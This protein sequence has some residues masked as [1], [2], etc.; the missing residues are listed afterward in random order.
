VDVEN[1]DLNVS[2]S[3]LH[4]G[5]E[6]LEA[7]IEGAL[8]PA[9]QAVVESHVRTCHRC[10]TEVE[11]W[12]ALFAAFSALPLVEPRAGFADRVMAGVRIHVPWHVRAAAWLG[13]LLPQTTKG[14]ALVAAF[15]ALPVLATGGAAAW[16]IR[17]PWVDL[18]GLLFLLETRGLAATQNAWHWLVERFMTS[19]LVLTL[20]ELAGSD[21]RGLGAIAL[22]FSLLT[23]ASIWVLWNYLVRTPSRKMTYVSYSF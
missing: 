3:M 5:S 7:L 9:E 11:E 23:L 1:G 13:S 8:D 18:Q 19:P 4:P 10:A 21:P 20:L 15:L 16:L 2:D 14:W 6:R 17:Q 22:A 12:R